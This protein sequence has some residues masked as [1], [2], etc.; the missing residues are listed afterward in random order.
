MRILTSKTK[1][2]CCGVNIEYD[3]G[4]LCYDYSYTTYLIC[5]LCKSKIYFE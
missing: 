3:A 2:K 5:P 4:D 1:C